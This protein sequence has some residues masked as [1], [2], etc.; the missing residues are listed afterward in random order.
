MVKKSQRVK[1]KPWAKSLDYI[2]STVIEINVQ[3]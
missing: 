2:Y 3:P 1:E